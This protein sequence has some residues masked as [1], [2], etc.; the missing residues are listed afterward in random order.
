LTP[1]AALGLLAMMTLAHRIGTFV[2]AALL[3]V[4]VDAAAATTPARRCAAAK[5]KAAGSVAS[6]LLGCHASAVKRGLAVDGECLAKAHDKLTSAFTKAEAKGG[7]A[8]SGDAT[9]VT[10]SLDD[11]VAGVTTALADG[12]T[13]DGQRCAAVKLKAAGKKAATKLGCHGRAVT[14]VEAVDAACLTKVETKFTT[15]FTGADAR[16]VCATEGDAATIETGHVDPL[17]ADVV[18][19]VP[20][21]TDGVVTL[22][23]SLAGLQVFP[24]DNWWNRDVSLATVPMNSDAVIDYIGRT[25]PLHADFGTTFGIPY[26]EVEGTQPKL[27]VTFLY[28]D[29]SDYGAPGLPLG[30][31]IPEVAQYTAGY[32]EGGVPGGG[33]SGDRHILLVDRD[34]GFLF[35]IYAVHFSGGAWSGG[36]GAIFDLTSNARRPDGWTSAD[37]AGLAILPGL[38]RADEVFDAGVINHALRFTAHGSE[39]YIYPASHDA[40]SGPAGTGRPPLGLRVRLKSTVDPDTFAAPAAVIIRAMQKYGLILADNGS[41]WFVTGAP[42]PRWDDELMH[43]EFARITGDDFEVVE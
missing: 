34:N 19:D 10:G 16:Y 22:N 21:T 38:V 18:A 8:S 1:I 20:A 43:D 36:S 39:G 4:A 12:G 11:F 37:A 17:V 33:S 27:P 15:A 13:P 32:V 30:Y 42:D 25:K 26:I 7:C 35:E 40:T 24:T 5:L 3:T 29:E 14:K 9:T 41:D 6:K 28:D 31:P 23:G 2:L